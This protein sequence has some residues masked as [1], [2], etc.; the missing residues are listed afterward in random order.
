MRRDKNGRK[1]PEE[2]AA[3]RGS[4]HQKNGGA[5]AAAKK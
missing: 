1:Q 3:W 5:A 4:A 2:M